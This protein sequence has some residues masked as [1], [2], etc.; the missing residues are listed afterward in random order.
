MY[1][2]D[3]ILKNRGWYLENDYITGA[4]SKAI[5]RLHDKLLRDLRPYANSLVDAFGITDESLATEIV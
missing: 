2:I 1:A 5:R 4:K 3:T